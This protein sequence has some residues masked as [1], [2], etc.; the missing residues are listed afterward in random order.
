M[1][2]YCGV[3]KTLRCLS[4]TRLYIKMLR[5]LLLSTFT[6]E[7]PHAL[8]ALVPLDLLILKTMTNVSQNM[9]I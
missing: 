7:M 9:C 6:I 4:K 5:I 2:K 1:W 8:T 3:Y